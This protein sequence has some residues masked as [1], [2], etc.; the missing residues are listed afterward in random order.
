[1]KRKSIY[2]MGTSS[3]E[4]ICVT[5]MTANSTPYTWH[6]LRVPPRWVLDYMVYWY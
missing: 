3:N 2:D 4:E 6:I 1:M 5:D